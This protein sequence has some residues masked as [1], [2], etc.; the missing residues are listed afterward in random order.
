MRG[1]LLRSAGESLKHEK[2]IIC[3]RGDNYAGILSPMVASLAQAQEDLSP[4]VE[5]LRRC[6]QDAIRDFM[7]EQAPFMYKMEPRTQANILRD[8]MVNHIKAEFSEDEPGV[9]HKS[10]AGLFLLN[11]GNRYFLR[12]KK[13]D[14]RLRTRNHP[15][16]LSLD[17]LLQKPLTLFP[18]LEPATHLNV[19]YKRGVT[20]ASSEYWITCPDGGQLDWKFSISEPDE[21]AQI[22][23]APKPKPDAP[24][25]RRVV[26][27]RLR[28]TAERN[29]ESDTNKPS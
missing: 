9:S 24:S 5:R 27:K 6:V 7:A 19:G 22:A 28:P 13:L 2:C 14:R 26:P 8:Y 3:L 20:L 29:D 10:R 4:Y 17:Y 25:K 23:A 18:D 11:I 16:Q 12:F 15:T 21:P 1:R